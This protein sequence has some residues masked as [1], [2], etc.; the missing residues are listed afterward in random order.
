MLS[1]EVQRN[2]AG[3]YKI[4]N[5]VN[6]K[7]YI[8]SSI[9]IYNRKHTHINKLKNR[10]HSCKH[11][12]YSYHK[13]GFD[14]FIFEVLEYCDNYTEREQYYISLLKPEYNKRLIA[15]NN[16][17]LV[18]TDKTKE[19][20]SQKLKNRYAKNEI[21]AYNQKHKQKEVEQYD[22]QGNYIKSFNSPKE[23]ELA[24]NLNAGDISKGVKKESHQ[25]GGFQWK[26][27][28]SDKIIQSIAR[29]Q[30]AKKIIVT[31]IISNITKNFNSLKEFAEF[32]SFS[33]SSVQKALLRG[34]PYLNKYK[35]EYQVQGKLGELLEVPIMDNQQP[36]INLND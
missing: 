15:Q 5:L 31:N 23:A 10:E 24:L 17:G 36:S 7:F 30:L 4:T 1:K 32:K 11:L 20:I 3:V 14:N 21:K 18:V 34:T 27:K 12:E 6:N 19:L 35:I 29:H 8:G 22:L 28:D 25:R 16:K 13:Y 26:Y 2:K 33:Y 9:N